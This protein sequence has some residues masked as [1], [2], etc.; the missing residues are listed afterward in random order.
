MNKLQGFPSV[1]YLS[2]EESIARRTHLKEQFGQYGIENIQSVISKRF[3]ECDDV[4]YGKYVHTLTDASKG[5]CTSHMKCIKRWLNETEEPI[6]FFCEDDLSL[7]TVQYWNFTWKEFIE[8]LPLDWDVV[9]LMWVRDKIEKVEFRN[10]LPDDWGASA[11]I[12]K[13]EYA[14]KLVD[15]YYSTNEFTFDIPVDNWSIQPI[16][17]NLIFLLGKA[18]GAPLFVEEVYKFDTTL[19]NSEEFTG[20]KDDWELIDG[21]G[22]T[23]ITSYNTVL[24][25]WKENSNTNLDIFMKMKTTPLERYSCDTDNPIRNYDLARWYH[26]QNQTAAA[27]SFYLRAADRTDDLEL[28]Y[29]CLLHIADCFKKQG[30][31]NYTIKGLYQQATTIL[32]KRPEAYYFLSVQQEHETQ[33]AECYTTSNIALTFC[34]FDCEP[35]RCDVGYPGK[36]GLIFE[37]AV[38]A[39]WWGKGDTSRKLFQDLK[40]NYEL[41]KIHYD[42]VAKNL[43]NLGCNVPEKEIKYEQN[44]YE[45][46][47][48]KFDGMEIIEKNYAQVFQDLFILNILKGKRNGTYLEIGAQEPYYQNNTVLLEKQFEWK[49]VSVEIKEDLCKMFAEQRSNTILCKDATT[50]D[51]TKLLDQYFD[52]KEIDYLQLDIEPSKNTF[53]VL[54]GIPFETYKFATI[55]YEHDHYVDM[56]TSYRDKSRRYLKMMGYELV[57]ANVSADESSPFE[58][59]WV[60]SDL[61][62]KETIEKYKSIQEVTDVRKYFY[63]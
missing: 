10:R 43:M 54:L 52:T 7:E 21:Q 55:T 13:R 31:R 34:D 9:Q 40:N 18:Y 6:G 39:Y 37:K 32:P 62:D 17:E 33:Y 59:W 38:S 45:R 57:V 5:C 15:T 19:V 11:Y 35:L 44:N 27:I 46:L 50:I 61:V 3:T 49:G 8:A 29:E 36:Y 47:R 56:T 60:H 20:L 22:P 42:L 4:L 12:L 1:Y 24:N 26:N 58:D 48:F 30:N 23:H 16:V 14:Q 63:K 25:C 51:Y 28:S 41:D 2:L 53:E